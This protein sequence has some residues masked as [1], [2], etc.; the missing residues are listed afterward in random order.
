MI[1]PNVETAEQLEQLVSFTRYP[2]AGVR[3]IGAERAT[4][5]G[6]AIPEHVENCDRDPPLLIPIYESHVAFLNRASLAA[7]PGVEVCWQGPADHSAT[8][9]FAGKWEGGDVADEVLAI[10]TAIAAAGKVP[11]IVCT[12]PNDVDHRRSQGFKCLA[13]G[14]DT[15]LFVSGLGSMLAAAGVRARTMNVSLTPTPDDKP[16]SSVGREHCEGTLDAKRKRCGRMYKVGVTPD[17]YDSAGKP[18]YADFGMTTFSSAPSIEVETIAPGGSELTSAQ[19][20]GING[21][22]V[23]SK[24]VTAAS[25]AD[26]GAADLIC[27]SRFGVGFDSVNVAACTENDVA[28]LITSGA[29]D[30]SMAEATVGWMLALTHRIAEKHAL[31]KE[32]RWDDRSSLMGVEIRDRVFGAVGLGGIAKKTI[33]LL[34]PFG[35]KQPLAFDPF[36]STSD[37][38]WFS[39]FPSLSLL[40]LPF[41]TFEC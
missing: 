9:G 39:F 4:A 27:V 22:L 3:G 6:G 10:A 26:G 12:S 28:V 8:K 14:T 23:L 36:A 11:A 29:V 15:G 30:H 7:V 31:V 40:S 19:L 38:G 2:P 5:F 24:K 32:G 17:F 41:E 35:M 13:L 37:A 21:A 25:L 34:Q 18:L 33:A 16:P 1:V 20:R